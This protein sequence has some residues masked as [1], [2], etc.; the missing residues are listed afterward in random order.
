MVDE[1]PLPSKQSN[2]VVLNGPVIEE[3]EYLS[4]AVDLTGYEI[5]RI[6]MPAGWTNANLTFQISTD[7]QGFNDL[8]AYD[9][10][11]YTLVVITGA[12]VPLRDDSAVKK[13]AQFVKFRSGSRQFPVIQ[14]ERREFAIAVLPIT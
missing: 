1:P 5:V 6:T 8:F 10:T 12:A 2:L 14:R 9:G 11:E 7:G 3:G 4:D 13:A